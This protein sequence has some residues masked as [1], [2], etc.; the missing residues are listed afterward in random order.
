VPTFPEA[1]ARLFRL[2]QR[3]PQFLIA[4][5]RVRTGVRVGII[6]FC[7]AF[8]FQSYRVRDTLD[9]TSLSVDAAAA[10]WLLMLVC[11]LLASTVS[12]MQF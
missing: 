9:M 10:I 6:D 11:K 4:R 12:C 2:A 3:I 7:D 5:L 8:L 1:S